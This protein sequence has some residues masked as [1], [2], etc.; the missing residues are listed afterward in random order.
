MTTD[1]KAPGAAAVYLNR[2][3]TVDDDKH[4]H[5]TYARLK[6][7]TEKGKE[8][9][10]VHVPYERGNFKVT[11]IHGRTIHADGTVIPLTAKPSDLTD[12]KTKT[13]QVNDMVFTLPAVEVGS[14]LE[15]RLELRYDD[16]TVSSP[17]WD[18]QQPYF[19][20][21]AHY[22]FVPSHTGFITNSR[23]EAA[24]KLL[25]AQIGPKEPKVV[26]DATG[27]YSYDVTDVPAIPNEDWMPPLNSLNWRVQFYYSPYTSGAD[28]WNSEGKRWAKESDR[29]ANPSKTLRE[30]VGQI[31]AA[32]DTDE[33]KA[34]K[35]Y[36]A[37]QKLEN[38]DFTREK[39]EAER[40]KE[41]IKQIKD[42]E[43]VWNEKT[44][45]SDQ[46][47]L[48]FVALARAAGLQSWPMQVVNRD[49]AIFDGNYLSTYQLDDYVAIVKIGD[50]ETYVDPGQKLCP[51]GLLAWK[52]AYAGGIRDSATGPKPEM[53]PAMTYVQTQIQRVA[54]LTVGADGSLTGTLRI[55]MGGEE[56]LHWRHVDLKN[57]PDEVKKQFN[58]EIRGEVP[59][60]VQADFDHFLGME[61][62]DVQ[63]MA[64]VNVSGNLGTATGK[65]FFLPGAFFESHAKHPFVT[66]DKRTI[67]VDV[68]FARMF[69]DDVTYHL[70]NGYAVESLPTATDLNWPAHALMKTKAAPITGGVQMGRVMAY[71]Y[72]MLE[73]NEYADLHNFYQKVATADQQQVVLTRAAAKVGGQ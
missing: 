10:T 71:N 18:V 9:A 46:L 64:I 23:G 39:S 51:F 33:Q 15:Y 17:N 1:P 70:P 66:E 3:E 53:T 32:S 31:V 12:L 5:T 43:G 19:V 48:L 55:I 73:A 47:A 29:F 59:D 62:P 22:F 50:K 36:D 54:D 57:D 41:K 40:K 44:G 72:T 30:A 4:Y 67:P 21:K 6:I 27:R 52:H 25:T 68:K 63:L 7:L 26:R 16:N 14:I 35:I 8:L 20:H 13:F 49:R 42:A 11:D 45:S 58:E 34:H 38:T 37:V 65:R 28:F 60:G 69:K 2:E 24:D 56:A 61:N